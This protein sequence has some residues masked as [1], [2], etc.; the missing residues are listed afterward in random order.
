M[1]A[2]TGAVVA[3]ASLDVPALFGEL[4][5]E[6]GEDLLMR[7]AVWMTLRESKA[8]FAIEGEGDRLGRAH[9]F[10]INEVLRRDGVIP[11]PVIL[12]ISA[13]ITDDAGERR[14]YD[15]VLDELSQ[16]LMR[17]V[18]EQAVFEASPHFSG[19]DYWPYVD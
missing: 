17:A 18:R 2:K 4:T 6:F 19:Q 10:L 14:A 9:R 8:T 3:A 11:A 16:P 1:I 7:A 15:Q 5:A 12:P 13:V